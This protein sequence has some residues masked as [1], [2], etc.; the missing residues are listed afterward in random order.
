MK[1]LNELATFMARYKKALVAAIT[2]ALMVLIAGAT[3]DGLSLTEGLLALAALFTSGAPT[4][5]VTN[6]PPVPEA[7][8]PTQLPANVK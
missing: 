7:P 2:A 8:V 4:A 5:Y 6:K 3:S 1:T